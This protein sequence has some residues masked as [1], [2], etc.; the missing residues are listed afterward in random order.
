MGSSDDFRTS[1]A[2]DKEAID[3]NSE[4]VVTINDAFARGGSLFMTSRT[5]K[6]WGTDFAKSASQVAGLDLPFPDKITL[7]LSKFDDKRA[8]CWAI[9]CVEHSADMATW[10]HDFGIDQDAA[11]L[12]RSSWLSITRGAVTEAL[13]GA[14]GGCRRFIHRMDEIGGEVAEIRGNV[15]M[16]ASEI[17]TAVIKMYEQGDADETEEAEGDFGEETVNE[18]ANN[19]A[20]MGITSTDEYEWQLELLVEMARG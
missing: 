7:I 5:S 18:M 13:S 9:R 8:L 14:H 4:I 19:A 15:A 3:A 10:Y 20:A 6:A 16:A 17:A 11:N 2:S 12:L 1:V